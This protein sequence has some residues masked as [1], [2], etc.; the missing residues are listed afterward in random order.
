MVD[1]VTSFLSIFASSP[2][3]AIQ[4]HMGQVK[5][6]VNNLPNFFESAYEKNWEQAEKQQ[7]QISFLENEADELKQ[8]IRLQMPNNLFMPVSRSDLLE[9]VTEQDSIANTAKDVAGIVLGRKIN[10]PEELRESY[11]GFVNACV[12]AVDKASAAVDELD[13]LL[14]TGF[15]GAEARLVKKIILELDQLERETD[16]I[17]V[18]VRSELFSIEKQLDPIDAMFLYQ[19]IFK[20]GFIADCAQKV[21]HRLQLLIAN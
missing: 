4:E 17:Q 19:V 9:L 5:Q 1:I 11:F 18:H 15:K 3:K 7:N 8:Q 12:T 13:D 20:T 21:G 14:E 10:L 2:F 16:D 6:C